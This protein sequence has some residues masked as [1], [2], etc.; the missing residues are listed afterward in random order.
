MLLWRW[1]LAFRCVTIF[2]CTSLLGDFTITVSCRKITSPLL[3]EFFF[4]RG[5]NERATTAI[6]VAEV[7][8]AV[9]EQLKAPAKVEPVGA[10]DEKQKARWRLGQKAEAQGARGRGRKAEVQSQR[11]EGRSRI[12]AASDLRRQ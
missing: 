5:L 10:A 1:E 11:A 4:Q 2:N 3:A 12:T 6:G 9:M 8:A 7:F